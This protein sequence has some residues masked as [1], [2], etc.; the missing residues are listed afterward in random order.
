MYPQA[1]SRVTS[2]LTETNV[3]KENASCFVVNNTIRGTFFGAFLSATLWAE[4]Q[5]RG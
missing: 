5:V 2:K 3:T 1:G 4:E